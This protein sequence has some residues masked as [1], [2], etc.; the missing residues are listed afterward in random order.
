MMN[1]QTWIAGI[2]ATT[3]LAVSLT[4]CK[5]KQK[6]METG[7][8]LPVMVVSSQPVEFQ[9]MYSASIRGR[10]DVDIMPQVLG[11]IMR[12]CVKEGEQVK[13]GQVLAI[14]D[15]VP[16]RAALRT[17]QANVSA[18][19]AKTETA[20]IEL[21]GKQALFD[22]KVISEYDLSLARNQLAVA[23][24]ELEQAKAQETDARNN[25]SYTEIK[26]PSN[27]VVGT[28]PF[29]IGALVSP[30]M[31]QPFTV[32][33][34]N[35]EMYVYF[36]VS[37]NKLRQL[38]A[39]YGS[40]DK[41]I[42]EMPEVSL[43]LNDG[44]LYGKKGYVETVSGVVNPTTGA[45]QIKALFPNPDH[46]LLSGTIGNVVIQGLNADAILIP[47]TATVEL[48]DKVIAYRLKNGKAEAAYLTVD[49]LNDGNHFVVKQGLSVGDT[50]I[51]EGVGL[52]KEGMIVT[53]KTVAP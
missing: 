18:A 50:I 10:Q 5:P 9:E 43:Q 4:A 28:L 25:L 39:R 37:E 34:D 47:M 23:L 45:V 41:M 33:F 7:Q 35:S 31:T 53:P 44:T 21:Q 19:Q 51:A 27:G 12:L 16:Y 20:Q 14:I 36:S 15:Q 11:R 22:E 48:Q 40:I 49:R 13:N 24:A 46:E 2:T 8:T 6:G 17:A 32:V 29:R 26:S 30:N 42:S 38:R 1:R 3:L 52:V